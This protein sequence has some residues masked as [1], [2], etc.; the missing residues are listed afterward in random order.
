MQGEKLSKNDAARKI[1]QGYTGVLLDA[2][3]ICTTAPDIMYGT[4]ILSEF[5]QSPCEVHYR[6]AKRVMQYVKGTTDFGV[7]Y[8]KHAEVKLMGFNDSDWLNATEVL[9]GNK[10]AVSI[11][12]NLVFHG[13]T[14]NIKIKYH[15]LR[16]V[17]KEVQVKLKNCSSEDQVAKFKEELLMTTNR[18][19]GFDKISQ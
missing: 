2:Y 10:S 8:A 19:C 14:K 5:K 11:V 3:Y 13:K 12:K 17:E 15:F 4:S 1:M 6:A 18:N 7:L 9:S 16:E